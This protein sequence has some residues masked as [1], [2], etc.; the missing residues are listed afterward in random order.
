MKQINFSTIDKKWQKEWEKSKVF[1]AKEDDKKEKY[2]ALAMYPYPSANGLHMGHAFNYTIGDILARFMR[3]NGKSVLHPMG[4]DSFGLPAENAAIKDGTHPGKYTDTAIKRFIEQQKALGLSYDWS[5]KLQSHDPEYY[6]WN[7]YFFLQ[8]LKKG[9]AYRKDSS[10]NWCSKCDT[11][12]ANEQVNDGK[13]WRHK[14]TEV[15]IKKLE[16]WF[17]KTTQYADEL[18]KGLDKLDWP[19]RIKSMQRNWIGKSEGTEVLFEINGE[20]WPVFTTRA[21]TLFGVTF[22]VISAQHS[23]LN[24][25]VTKEQ[26][27]HVDVFLKKIKSTKQEDSDKMEKE[28]VFT[29]SYAL[30]PLTRK[31]I[32]IWVGNFVVADYGSG[33]VMAV[34]AHDSRDFAFA[35]K[36]NIP[37]IEVVVPNRIDKKNP[38]VK[39]K[40]SK[41]RKN[42]QAIVRN[43]KTGKILFLKSHEHKWITLPMGGVEGDESVVDAAK[44]EVKEETGYANLKY[45]KTLG[46]MIKAEYFANHKD[47][48]RVSYTN[49]VM[50]DLVDE[51]K[52]KLD[53][54]EEGKHEVMWID[55]KDVVYPY[56]VHAELNDWLHR[57]DK[58]DYAYTDYGV[59]VNSGDFNGLSSEE[60]IKHIQIVL[61]E[62]KLGKAVV[63]YKL[64][65][66][67]ISR[68]RY[69]GT[70]I[71]IIYC[72][73][74]GAVP[75]PER[76][77][78]VLLPEKVTFGK[79]NPLFS[80]EKFVKA[81]CPNCGKNGRRE[82]DTMDTFIDSSWYYLRFTDPGNKKLPLSVDNLSYWMP[83][84]FYIGGS[85]H[86]CG[87]LIYS[88][89]ITK[90][91]RDL[92]YLKVDEPFQRLFNQGMVHGED[93]VVMSKSRGNVV[94]PLDMTSKYG[95]DTLR[96]FLVSV[97]APDKDSSWS[98]TG[99]ESMYKFVNKVWNYANSVNFSKSSAKVQHKVNKAIVEVTE[100][101]KNLNYN[102]AVIKLRA[103]FDSFED[104]I[105]KSD[106]ATYLQLIA[107]FAPH[108]AEELWHNV[109]G[110]NTFV[111]LSEWP[112]ADTKRINDNID[113]IEESFEKTVSDI[114]NVLRIV[115]DK[116]RKDTK[117]IY[118]YA[119]PPEVKNFDKE[120]LAKRL[121]I[122]VSIFAVNDNKKYD[123]SG[124][125]SKAK[126][127]KPAIYVE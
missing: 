9:L 50:F 70:P 21:D 40:A 94:D 56:I 81:K 120:V 72:D 53:K 78:P 108:I 110:Y 22:L 28:G 31:K 3:M 101:I 117:H 102:M 32:P 104:E 38:P 82:T 85:E 62:K 95:A 18:L 25:L 73:D 13:C 126:P 6:K 69:W 4:F 55:K 5:R 118:L 17:F 49:A 106:F 100:D 112:T 1:E 34:P 124:K 91:L 99:V 90:T 105:D 115:K 92:G 44:R 89:F 80:N 87:H 59:L 116:E 64:R 103:L 67:L 79:G 36:Y 109:L 75:V 93:G 2:Y 27:K 77:L 54:G 122:D 88:R 57:W 63:N 86:A 33:V 26:K 41:E 111:S 68:Q 74:C 35:K 97:A 15:N 58:D 60:A 19:E 16:Q 43:P 65:D 39:G 114:Q 29:G 47:E 113:K 12:L 8:F 42:V 30:H 20:R 52:V 10:V 51:K 96:L 7:Q 66:W 107:S 71:P 76:E 37:L 23:R 83:V 123:P 61:E 46:G 24:E 14:D 98:S 119:I 121:G 11:V 48:N 45:V 125:A 84:D 127:G